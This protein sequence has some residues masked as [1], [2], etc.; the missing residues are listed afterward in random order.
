VEGWRCLEEGWAAFQGC[1]GGEE[2]DLGERR[3]QGRVEWGSWV[4]R[5]WALRRSDWAVRIS[6]FSKI[7]QVRSFLT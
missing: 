3:Q 4:R 1:D 7:G 5:P 2:F 6:Y